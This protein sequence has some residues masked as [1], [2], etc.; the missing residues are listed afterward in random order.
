MIQKYLLVIL[1]ALLIC[2]CGISNKKADSNNKKQ[3]VSTEKRQTSKKSSALE[4]PDKEA[5]AVA[6]SKALKGM[7][8]D[9]IE[10]LNTIIM[11]S[12]LRLEQGFVFGDIEK[13]LSDP[14]SYYWNYIEHTGEILI[15]YA[16][17]QEVWEQKESIKSNEN[18]TEKEFEEKYGQKVSDNNEYDA[19]KVIQIF[20]E[21]KTTIYDKELKQD[22]DNMIT[23][24]RKA[25][26]THDVQ[27]IVNIYRTLHDMDYYLLRYGPEDVGKYVQDKSTIEKYYGMLTCYK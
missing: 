23:Y 7:A 2:G 20:M 26:D 4:A 21:L 1:I 15:G 27:Y 16:Y 19:E 9:D 3:N 11:N 24:L 12:N 25:K 10:R 5:V 14:E 22:F 18:L 13:R 8:D 17:E 6:R